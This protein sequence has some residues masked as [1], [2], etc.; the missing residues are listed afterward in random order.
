MS[1][2][3]SKPVKKK[4]VKIDVPGSPAVRVLGTV[5]A[6]V[7]ML[8]V[9]VSTFCMQAVVWALM[10]PFTSREQRQHWCGKIFRHMSSIV[11]RLQPLWKLKVRN[12]SG[13]TGSD[14]E[15]TIVMANHLSNV[16]PF[17][18][19]SALLPWETKYIAKASLF[20]VPFGGWAMRLAGDIPVYFT[21]G[22]GGWATRKGTVRRMMKHCATL[23]QQ[24]YSICVFPEGVRSYNPDGPVGDFKNGF[25]SLAVE[26]GAT[27]LP[28]AVSGSE[29]AWP[30]GDWRIGRRDIYVTIGKPI[31]VTADTDVD[32]LR[33]QVHDAITEMRERHPDRIAL[34]KGS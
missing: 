8:T 21:S 31:K 19:C 23:L 12:E 2:D 32:A 28:V 25:F 29:R 4:P 10:K 34:A 9:F 16:D 3:Q 26:T 27:V 5:W 11:M 14:L 17:V 1:S 18:V 33:Q 22:K 6:L 13:I 24:A 7:L 15:S 20:S 30:R